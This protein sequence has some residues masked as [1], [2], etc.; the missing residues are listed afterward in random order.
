[1]GLAEAHK[2]D[3]N[4]QLAYQNLC[5]LAYKLL[6]DN[7]RL[8]SAQEVGKF[9]NTLGLLQLQQS[10]SRYGLKAYYAFP[11]LSLQQF[12]VAVHLSQIT[13]IEQADFVKKLLDQDLLSNVI[14]FFAGLTCLTNNIN[15]VVRIL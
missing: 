2:F 7:K 8:F 10:R 3:I 6:Q 9:D 11:H 14:P 5:L 12:L 4:P 15:G 13:D 1:M